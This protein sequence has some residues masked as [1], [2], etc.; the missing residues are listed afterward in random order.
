M[1]RQLDD[2]PINRLG[3]TGDFAIIFF[4]TMIRFNQ[5]ETKN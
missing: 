2:T 5:G 4:G 3:S 1:V